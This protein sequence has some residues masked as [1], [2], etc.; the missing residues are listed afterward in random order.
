MTDG[1][2]PTC[3]ADDK[4]AK[5]ATE[6][7][8]GR[9]ARKSED[10]QYSG[11]SSVSWLDQTPGITSWVVGSTSATLPLRLGA[12]AAQNMVYIVQLVQHASAIRKNTVLLDRN[13]LYKQTSSL[14]WPAYRILLLG[15]YAQQG[16]I[17]LSVP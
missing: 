8:E 17:T 5:A 10:N 13:I 9:Q 14:C 1:W 4:T 3:A 7:R 16:G 15:Q 12:P 11:Y 2:T 6:N